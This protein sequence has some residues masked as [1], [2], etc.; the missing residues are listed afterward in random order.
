MDNQ[1]K[2]MNLED[3]IAGAGKINT[4]AGEM[5]T[6]MA[7]IINQVNGI[8][9]QDQAHDQF[10]INMER[11]EQENAE[12]VNTLIAHSEIM[13]NYAE[14]NSTLGSTTAQKLVNMGSR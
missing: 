7:N 10:L 13:K 3:M 11:F 8:V 4:L 12:L 9:W 1:T 14:E 5:Q 2:V 6:L